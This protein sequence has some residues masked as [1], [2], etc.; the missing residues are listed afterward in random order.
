MFNG[1]KTYR[2]LIKQ[3]GGPGKIVEPGRVAPVR[4]TPKLGLVLSIDF[5]DLEASTAAMTVDVLGLRVAV[6]RARDGS[7]LGSLAVQTVIGNQDSKL[8]VKLGELKFGSGVDKDDA[9]NPSQGMFDNDTVRFRIRWSEFQ[10][11]LN[12]AR[13]MDS[14]DSI[15][16]ASSQSVLDRIIEAQ[17]PT[18]IR[19]KASPRQKSFSEAKQEQSAEEQL[20]IERQTQRPV[21]TIVLQRFTVDWQRIFKDGQS[22]A[23]TV[24]RSTRDLLLSPE[25]SQFSVIVHSVRL[26][27]ETPNSRFPVV[28]DSTSSTTSFFDLCLRF[29]G[30][31]QTELVKVD[32]FDLN[33]AHSQGKTEKITIQTSEDFI[34]KAIDVAN[35]IAVSTAQLAGVDL[36]MEWDDEHQEYLVSIKDS[37]APSPG[38]FDTEGSYTPPSSDT[39]YDISKARV[40]PFDVQV[41]FVRRPQASRY[42]HLHNVRG[43]KLMNY[44]TRKL[45]FKLDRANLKFS[46]YETS[47][48]KGPPDQLI[49]LLV[50]VYSQRMKYK[51]V[52]MLSAVSFEDWKNLA[53]RDT[54]DDE[55][56]DGDLLRVTGNLAGGTA[57]YFAK[58]VG[59]GIG[60]G[61]N[62]VTRVLGNEIEDATDKVGARAVGAGV[63]SVVTGLGA[64]VGNTVTGG[65]S[66]TSTFVFMRVYSESRLTCSLHFSTFQSALAQANY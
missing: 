33:L 34:W 44:F 52:S 16:A 17:S 35:R 23:T 12:E 10:L 41:S 63:N 37:A 45:K 21:C 38:Y 64:G 13:T 61:I 59:G 5:I 4:S 36:K 18:S 53:A 54:G 48:V 3:Q 11:T 15:G 40:S 66:L 27:D 14:D 57:G 19:S 51:V 49:Q 58:Q 26:L 46:R 9:T 47:N 1:S 56:Q 20:E 42:K 8:A 43:A 7:P 29:R 24:N 60:G 31:L 30:P 6:V 39:L 32:L 22:T 62:R 55:F 50:A 2:V 25:R 65:K 28:F